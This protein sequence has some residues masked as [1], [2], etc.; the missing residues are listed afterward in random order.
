[1]SIDYWV[2]GQSFGGITTGIATDP[3]AGPLFVLLALALF[4]NGA[5]S[6]QAPTSEPARRQALVADS[7]GR[8]ERTLIP[9]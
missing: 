4:P 2:L 7:V 3:N 9:V 1:L 6:V 5:P 8:G